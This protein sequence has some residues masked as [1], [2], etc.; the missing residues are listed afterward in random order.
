M[1]QH[2]TIIGEKKYLKIVDSIYKRFS[3]GTIGLKTSMKYQ[4]LLDND[5][6]INKYDRVF[7]KYRTSKG[8]VDVFEIHFDA[9]QN[10]IIEIFLVK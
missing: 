1:A 2:I 7:L 3:K 5:Y 6:K 8:L 9:N 10:E 4:E